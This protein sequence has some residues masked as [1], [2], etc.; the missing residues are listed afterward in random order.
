MPRD[1]TLSNGLLLVTF[2]ST[3]TL[4]DIYFPHVGTEN[5]AYRRHSRLGVWADGE[6]AWMDDAEWKRTLRYD[7]DTLVTRVEVENPRLHVRL[8]VEDAV[9]F[10]RDIL[11]RRFAVQA[12]GDEPIEVRLYNHLDVALGGNTV[13]DTVFFHPE[14]QSLIAYKNR[15]YLLL[16]GQ[17][18]SSDHLDSWTTGRKDSWADAE[19]GELDGL[20]IAFGSI[21]CVGELRLGKVEAGRPTIAYSWLAA[22]TD[23]EAVVGLSTLIHERG[24]DMFIER[25]RHFWHAW[26]HKES[27]ERAG[28]GDLPESVQSLYRRS[29]LIA[30][31]HMDHDGAI[32]ASS[33]SEITGAF[34]P[35]GASGP[36]MLDV[37]LG[38][39]SY[40]YSWPRDSSFV[41][42]ALDNAGYAGDARG[43]L[44]F[45]N[46]TLV[47]QTKDGDT[48]G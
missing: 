7:E 38:Q 21:D 12:I 18:E 34:S 17:T 44:G 5:H 29:L 25:T 37:F 3:Y 26:V 15:H 22:G 13:G 8:L 23:L 27:D 32:I 11:L 10:D 47:H 42:L 16:G 35:H 31:A 41:A 6:F 4:S 28:L 46:R 20:P 43:Y 40:A 14:S 39:E 19:D 9:D 30:K 1:L 48:Q 45:C 2:D 33:D 36:P 24:P